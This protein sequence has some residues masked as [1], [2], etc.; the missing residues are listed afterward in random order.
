MSQTQTVTSPPREGEPVGTTHTHKQAANQREGQ[1]DLC[2]TQPITEMDKETT[3]THSQPQTGTVS[4]QFNT[5][6]QKEGQGVVCNTQSD[7]EKMSP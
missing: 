6:N 3:A 2:H 5:A 7:R 1:R 4:R